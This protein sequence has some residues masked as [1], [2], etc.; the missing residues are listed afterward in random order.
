[1][2]TGLLG[3]TG[4]RISRLC[5]G[6]LAMGPLQSNMPLNEGVSLLEQAFLFGVNFIDTAEL[7][8]TYPYIKEALKIKPDAV[9]CTKSYSY[10]ASGA[11]HSFKLAT[12]GIGR[13]YID[14][15]LL[16]EQE[17]GH[18]I[19][20]HYEAIEYLLKRKAQGLI[21]AVGL[22]THYVRCV[23]GALRYPELDVIFP[24]IN[25]T[26]IGIADGTAEEML[27]AIKLAH[28]A[29]KGLFAM[30]PLG[31]G[32][33]LKSRDEA[34]KFILSVP[35]LTSIAIGIK[36]QAELK[37]DCDFFSGVKP[38]EEVAANISRQPRQLLIHDWCEG[39]GKCVD[40]CRNKAL[41]LIDGRS[42][43]DNNKC[44]LCSYCAAACP[45]FCIKII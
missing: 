24:L 33:L 15:F 14:I 4:I 39:C 41:K 13:E 43:V 45:Q 19:R 26:G 40:I 22:S 32:H 1:L 18:T 8:G 23:R 10:D 20:G 12:E 36:T 3:N 16:H 38:S 34:L 9:I 25:K 6:T 31:G 2:E 35:E 37:Y 27:A 29:G 17:S 30:K 11:E 5:F 42:V 28:K 7:Y 44:A 21:G